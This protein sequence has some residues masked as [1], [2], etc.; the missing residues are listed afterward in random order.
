[1]L[2]VYVYIV[3]QSVGISL[4]GVKFAFTAANLPSMKFV[5]LFSETA[6]ENVSKIEPRNFAT[7]RININVIRSPAD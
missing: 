4:L 7:H 5:V 1:M 2:L 6:V 3:E